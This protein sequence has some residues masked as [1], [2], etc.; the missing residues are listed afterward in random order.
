MGLQVPVLILQALLLQCMCLVV[1][2]KDTVLLPCL[3]LCVLQQCIDFL[4]SVPI[5]LML[6]GGYGDQVAGR[7]KDRYDGECHQYF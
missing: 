1:N 6:H 3:L 7:G 4:A 2:G 5:A